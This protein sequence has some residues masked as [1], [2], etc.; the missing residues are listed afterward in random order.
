MNITGVARQPL[1]WYA[2]GMSA[3]TWNPELYQSSHS[4]V[5]KFGRDLLALLAPQAGERILDVGCG[6][7]QL[8]AEIAQSGAEVQGID[9]AAAMVEQARGNFPSLRF[10]QVSATAL[11]YRE[12]FDAVFSNAVLHW[13]RDAE[14]AAAAISRALKPGGRF[15][16]EFGG[17]GNV[18]RVVDAAY[19]EL[20]AMGVAAPEKLNPWYYPSVGEYASLLEGHQLEVTFAALFDRPTPLE[21]GESGFRNWTAMF[22][23]PFTDAVPSEQRGELV[24]RLEERLAPGLRRNGEWSMDYRR[25]RVQAVKPVNR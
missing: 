1:I 17:H 21:G 18:Q 7:G 3:N 10:E 6:T 12:E 23:K 15:V 8:T 11:P 20:R 14:T 5:W 4:F 2:I 9:S 19:A 25:I 22:C 13:V 16:A 24:N